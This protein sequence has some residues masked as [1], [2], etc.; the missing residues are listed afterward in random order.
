MIRKIGFHI[1]AGL[2]GLVMA[3][4]A[5]MLFGVVVAFLVGSPLGWLTLLAYNASRCSRTTR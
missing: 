1:L 2:L 4:G 5:Y 3:F